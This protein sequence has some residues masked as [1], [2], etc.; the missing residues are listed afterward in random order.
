MSE[1]EIMDLSE[2]I[3]KNEKISIC[4]ECNNFKSLLPVGAEGSYVCAECASKGGNMLEKIVY[5]ARKGKSVL[6][7]DYL[8]KHEISYKDLADI[9]RLSEDYIEA[10][11]KG[12]KQNSN[13]K[14]SSL[15][16]DAIQKALETKL[17]TGI[18]KKCIY[19]K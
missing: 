10:I 4:S 3:D 12:K 14:D 11:I 1:I 15:L 16:M 8:L 2:F 9:S 13:L 17:N 18:V 6:L 7:H 5:A 19:Q